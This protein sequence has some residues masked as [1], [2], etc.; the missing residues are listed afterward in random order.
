MTLWQNK[1]SPDKLTAVGA[2]GWLA[3][4]CGHELVTI[5][6]VYTPSH[7]PT[8]PV[9]T[10]P[11]LELPRFCCWVFWN[12][13]IFCTMTLQNIFNFQHNNY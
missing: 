10:L 3:E 6:L 11:L 5:Y 1:N 7:G 13:N 2:K 9:E 8:P 4:K 12:N